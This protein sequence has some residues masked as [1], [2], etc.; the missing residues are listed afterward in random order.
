M[1]KSMDN[2]SIEMMRRALRD[3]ADFPKPGVV[4]KDITP[5]IGDPRLMRLSID[6]LVE[7]ARG[8][9]VDKIVGIDARGFIFAAVVADRLEAGFVPVRKKGKL[10][11]RT[12]ET[13]YELEYGTGTIEMHEDA[14][15]RG[16][17]IML[18]D[19]VLATGGTAAGALRLL[20]QAGAEIVAASFLIELR[21]LSGREKLPPGIRVESVLAF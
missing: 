10:P 11:W 21:F 14:V 1:K 20:Q 16:E 4:F 19:D 12:V 5:L 8:Q 2:N 13:S 9:K 7:H 15:T 17:K 6:A 18:V 3:V